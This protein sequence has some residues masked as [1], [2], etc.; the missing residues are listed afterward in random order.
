MEQLLPTSIA[1]TPRRRRTRLACTACKLRKRKCDGGNP[2]A[3]CTRYD[4]QCYYDQPSRPKKAA[5]VLL[6]QNQSQHQNINLESTSQQELPPKTCHDGIPFNRASDN[7]KQTQSASRERNMEAN[8]GVVFPRTLGLRLNSQIN[9]QRR[10]CP[11]WNLGIR[12]CSRRS[13]KSIT[14]IL[15]HNA[16]QEL[17]R[18]YEE[19]IQP[20]YGFLDL[21]S[22]YAIAQ[23][24]WEDPNAT[25]EFDSVL[26]GVAALG[27]MFS[28][29]ASWEQERQLVECSKEILESSGTLV[30]P[31]LD[32]AAGWLLRTLYLR[33]SSSPHASWMASC[34]ALHIIE[35]IGIH[36]ESA[37]GVI[38]LVY[39]DTAS[40][41]STDADQ[42][43]TEIKRRVF[44]IA[45]ILNT[46]IS[47]EYGRTRV[48]LQGES[49]RV[50]KS[51]GLDGDC[52]SVLI[53]LFQI[54]DNLDPS[55]DM[56]ADDL[57]KCLEQLQH[58][59]FENSALVLSQSV[60]AFTIYRRLQLLGLSANK[61]VIDRVI[62]LGRRGL[63]ASR[64]CID[65]NCPWWHVNNVPFQFTCVLLAID[66]PDSLLH[67][68][69]SMAILK[70]T[71]KHFGT[72][73]S[74]QA[75]ETVKRLVRLSQMRKQQD[76][77][78][79]DGYLL[80]QEEQETQE[81]R[82]L[83]DLGQQ[84]RDPKD[85]RNTED[86]LAPLNDGNS[87]GLADLSGFLDPVDWSAL[88][89]DP[90]NFEATIF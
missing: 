2:C 46:W 51:E 55:K 42:K 52:T 71:A 83:Q 79:L 74:Y 4:Y 36:Q 35:A 81:S 62:S 26:C 84:Q 13:E 65:D 73:K 76:A 23:R 87:N 68:R 28:S 60:L 5:A 77:V 85:Y 72:P 57:E 59:N 37:T 16:W 6:R 56:S 20:I 70:K 30:N 80:E 11:G 86:Q 54:S 25:N 22:V 27:S 69:E 38:S 29:Q 48:I 64:Q 14:W 78:V 32:D 66:T 49:C 41:P 45:K 44:W 34:T 1:R 3:S 50:P 9:A 89:Q 12:H 90:F 21:Q 88:I 58:Y 7:D 18:I 47:F 19:K 31:T 10:E 67:I 39:A 43:E 53:S 63:E 40:P 61:T 33:C 17:Y 24:R 75:F 8:S 82:H 15:S